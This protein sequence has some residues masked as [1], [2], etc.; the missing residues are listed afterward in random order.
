MIR[1]LPLVRRWFVGVVGVG[2]LGSIGCFST[3]KKNE[4]LQI[5]PETKSLLN[6]N[7]QG[8]PQL[9]APTNVAKPAS[10]DPKQTGGSGVNLKETFGRATPITTSTEPRPALP[11]PKADSSVSMASYNSPAPT[12]GAITLPE[13]PV[14]KAAASLPMPKLD[15]P[16]EVPMTRTTATPTGQPGRESNTGLPIPSPTTAPLPMGDLELPKPL[17]MSRETD[18]RP[19]PPLPPADIVLP[20]GPLPKIPSATDGPIPGTKPLPLPPA[21]PLRPN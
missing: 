6:T 19:R 4:V 16:Q 13:Q 7:A 18:S 8:K 12:G 20:S 1:P 10:F 9:P 3:G 15:L 2:V 5:Q 21:E 17:P 11:T 14:N